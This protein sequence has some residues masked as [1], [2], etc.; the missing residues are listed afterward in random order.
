MGAVSADYRVLDGAERD[1]A[2]RL[3]LPAEVPRHNA[4]V[5]RFLSGRSRRSENFPNALLARLHGLLRSTPD[6]GHHRRDRP[7]FG[8]NGCDAEVLLG[9]VTRPLW[10]RRETQLKRVQALPHQR[11]EVVALLPSHME[12]LRRLDVDALPP[13]ELRHHSVRPSRTTEGSLVQGHCSQVDVP[14]LFS[15]VRHL[16][17]ERQGKR[18]VR[19]SVRETQDLRPYW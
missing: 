19:R 4:L 15:P 8:E 1:W 14:L 5:L 17:L 9:L 2:H 12:V 3:H 13:V 6:R 7:R 10:V 16:R 11:C 18:R